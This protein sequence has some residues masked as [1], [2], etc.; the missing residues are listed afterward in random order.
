M[1]VGQ[2]VQ[3]IW[4]AD[5]KVDFRKSF[6]GLT[7]EAYGMG[8][9][10]LE[11]DAVVFVSRDKKRVKVLFSDQNGLW[12]CSKR[13][14]NDKMR[15]QIQFLTDPSSREISEGELVLL[16]EGASYSIQRKGSSWKTNEDY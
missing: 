13:F 10:V 14:H 12:V 3:R 6:D 5:Y 4:V 9:K 8:L 2:K 16:V 1:L 15:A 11:G 7:A